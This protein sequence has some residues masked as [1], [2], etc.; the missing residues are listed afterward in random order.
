VFN[1][2]RESMHEIRFTYTYRRRV[3]QFVESGAGVGYN[4]RLTKLSKG[5]VPRGTDTI[6]AISHLLDEILYASY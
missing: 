2:V 3:A 1:I 4:V 6:Y 5:L